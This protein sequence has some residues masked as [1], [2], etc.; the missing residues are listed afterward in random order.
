MDDIDKIPLKNLPLSGLKQFPLVEDREGS[1]PHP[2]NVLTFAL[3]RMDEVC[4]VGRAKDGTMYFASSMENA[5]EVH[6][7][8]KKFLD[9]IEGYLN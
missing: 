7:D 1:C 4:I 6:K 5:L 3:G 9:V 2:D 8:I